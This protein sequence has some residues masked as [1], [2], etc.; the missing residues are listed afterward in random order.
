MSRSALA[1]RARV[2]AAEAMR[3]ACS[4]GI[5]SS[6]ATIRRTV[7]VSPDELGAA[8]GAG[9]ALGAGFEWKNL[10]NM[11]LLYQRSY[12]GWSG[13]TATNVP[14][15]VAVMMPPEVISASTTT[16]SPSTDTGHARRLTGSATGVGRRRRI[17]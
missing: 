1:A 6:L 13:P 14:R 5:A 16:R 11:G 7:A 8:A 2:Y 17:A 3:R 12:A 15:H 9:A 4:G 10:S